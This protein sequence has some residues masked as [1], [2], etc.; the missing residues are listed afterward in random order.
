MTS[1]K[2]ILVATIGTRDLMFQTSSGQWYNI[3]DDRIRD[4]EIIGEQLEVLGEL[5]PNLKETSSF[6]DLTQYLLE[7][8]QAYQD[9]IKPVI[10]G[11]LF[12]N[13]IKELE[14]IYLIVTK[15]LEDIKE[16][17]KDTLYAGELI[18][19]WLEK[20]KSNLEVKLIYLGEDGT[21]PSNFESMFCWWQKTWKEII[22]VESNRAILLCLKG[23]VGQTSEAA[24]I[25]G[26]SL[27]GEQIQFYEFTQNTIQNRQG[28]PSDYSQP[29]LGTNYLWNRAQ[30][31]ALK[32][33]ERYDY[34]AVQS[35]LEPYFKNKTHWKDIPNLLK[36]NVA[37]NQGE[38][39][40]FFQL[41]KSSLSLTEQQRDKTWW[42]MGY[43]QAQL[44]IIRF[45]QHNTTEAMLHSYRAIEGILYRW[46]KENFSNELV[47]NS[48]QFPTL[49]KSLVEKHPQLNE[50]LKKTNQPLEL[51]GI[52][53][54]TLLESAM[55]K[56]DN[57][58]DFKAFWKPA[59]E[60]RNFIAHNL[61]GLAEKQ[62]FEA[63]NVQ[64][65]QQW[66]T[67][68]LNCL[69]TIA[70]QTYKSLEEA[71]LLP[72]NHDKIVQAIANF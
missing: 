29:F 24:R 11:N 56:A 70:G 30:K 58:L 53:M 67:R 43:E 38:F 50:F 68:I 60:M 13:K 27:Y 52:V 42:W 3:G 39:E 63:W 10:L 69:N 8:I 16:R 9:R 55:P 37:W 15:Q 54:R 59:R 26:L 21:N 18:K 66:Q 25:S 47:F 62:L 36:A 44:A 45:E 1:S 35:L 34:A 17:E 22:K 57:N 2:S 41:T 49:K 48:N 51:K 40:T 72:K 5:S 61:G 20:L 14:K 4:G 33:L 31:Q 7:N 23:G 46:A 71:S 64:T 12:Q 32:L 28:I 19:H 65:K 6:R